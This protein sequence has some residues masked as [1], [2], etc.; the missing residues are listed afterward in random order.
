MKRILTILL[1]V[2]YMFLPSLLGGRLF[3]DEGMWTLYNL[4]DAVYR[5]MRAEGLMLP[6]EALYNDLTKYSIHF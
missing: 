4:P 3:A 5:Q 2:N 6:K 1:V